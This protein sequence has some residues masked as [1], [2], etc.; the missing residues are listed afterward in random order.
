MWNDF[1]VH[2]V[3]DEVLLAEEGEARGLHQQFNAGN[4]G[5]MGPWVA[6]LAHQWAGTCGHHPT[7]DAER[8]EPQSALILDFGP[9]IRPTRFDV[10]RL[11]ALST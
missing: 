1:S 11:Q 9:S 4:C 10:R 2:S 8:V 3:D 6:S 7:N 5:S